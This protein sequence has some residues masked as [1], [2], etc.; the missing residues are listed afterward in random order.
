MTTLSFIMP[1]LISDY[2]QVIKSEELVAA[3][4]ALAA[5]GVRGLAGAFGTLSKSVAGANLMV[6]GISIAIGLI[7]GLI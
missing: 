4:G 3:K 2:A 7:F 6:S 1:S 5:G